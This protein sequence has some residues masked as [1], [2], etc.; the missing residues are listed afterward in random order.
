MSKPT[1]YCYDA[2]ILSVYDGDTCTARVSLG[3]DVFIKTSLRLHGIDTPEL[4]TGDNKEAGGRAKAHLA[5]QILGAKVRI[6]SLSREKY[7]RLLVKVWRFDAEGE[8]EAETVNE[9]MVRLGFAL[10]YDGGA[11]P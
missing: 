5:G 7:G 3:L 9:Q 8:T 2:E 11:K 1:L 4:K 10:A 6:Q